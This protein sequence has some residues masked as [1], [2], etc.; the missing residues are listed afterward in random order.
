MRESDGI[1][2]KAHCTIERNNHRVFTVALEN[3]P[4]I[5]TRLRTQLLNF[6]GL[7]HV[8]DLLWPVSCGGGLFF[9]FLHVYERDF[10]VILITA[11]PSFAQRSG[12]WLP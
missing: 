11:A 5:K 7:V 9:P 4:A 12:F 8:A 6:L 1:F 3:G 10:R 2:E